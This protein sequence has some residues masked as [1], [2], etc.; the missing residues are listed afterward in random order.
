MR[1]L[2]KKNPFGSVMIVLAILKSSGAFFPK[3]YPLIYRSSYTSSRPS[4]GAS[5]LRIHNLQT[6]WEWLA[7]QRM[8]EEGYQ[9]L[10]WMDVNDESQVVSEDNPQNNSNDE[11]D[12][13]FSLPLYP[14]PAVHLPCTGV[15]YTLN[16][17]EPRNVKMALDLTNEA[18]KIEDRKFCVVLRALDTSRLSTVATVMRVLHIDEQCWP[19]GSTSRIIVTCQAEGLVDIVSIENSEAETRLKKLMRSP[20]Y[21]RARVRRRQQHDPE[22]YLK[23]D[24]NLQEVIQQMVLDYQF[25]RSMYV[26]GVGQAEVPVFARENLLT[27][28]G[29]WEVDDFTTEDSF[30][31]AAYSWQMLCNTVREGRQISL[32]SDRNEIMIAEASKKGGPLKLPIHLEDLPPDVQRRIQSMEVERQKEFALKCR[33][34]PVLDFCVMLH[35]DYFPERVQLLAR[36]VSRERERLT[37]IA[38][39][40]PLTKETAKDIPSEASR[41]GAWFEGFQ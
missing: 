4:R 16:N 29:D 23:D 20:D 24:N 10:S 33:M 6:A 22:K 27:S 1:E 8:E 2:N 40:R 30:W 28:M 11:D 39:L 9:H 15:N 5:L 38:L 17:I 13:L 21:L 25:V 12:E 34:D 3:I 26:D 32:S 19:D 41:K 31:N 36:M 18:V 7:D 37:E 35:L 14:V